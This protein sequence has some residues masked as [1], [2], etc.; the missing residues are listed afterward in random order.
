MDEVD[1][2]K[3]ILFLRSFIISIQQRPG[4]V[5]GSD[6]EFVDL[7]DFFVLLWSEYSVQQKRINE[8]EGKL[9]SLSKFCGVQ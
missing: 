9:E 6:K 5:A 7:L 2:V 3:Q 1:V 4:F 8:L